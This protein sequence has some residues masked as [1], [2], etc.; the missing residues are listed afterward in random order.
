MISDEFLKSISPEATTLFEMAQEL[1]A[2][3]AKLPD[4]GPTPC[5]QN[6]SSCVKACTPRGEWIASQIPDHSAAL[7]LE[8]ECVL[9]DGYDGRWS[10]KAYA[11][12]ESYRR[13]M[14]R[15]YDAAGQGRTFMGEPFLATMRE[16]T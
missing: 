16:L 4:N 11:A 10:D 14:G 6:F 8:L 12:L 9:S 5:C 1:L 3:R 7:A 15:A 13:D 2:A